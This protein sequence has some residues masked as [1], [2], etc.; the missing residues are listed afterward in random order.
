MDDSAPLNWA[1][2]R[3]RLFN[4]AACAASLSISRTGSRAS[5][6]YYD[7]A[8]VVRRLGVFHDP[9]RLRGRI[10]VVL[11]H[12]IT[13]LLSEPVCARLAKFVVVISD[14]VAVG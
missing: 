8:T 9:C 4:T 13:K 10:K 2:L 12:P 3:R 7:R 11:T 6:F 14:L 5:E 1:H